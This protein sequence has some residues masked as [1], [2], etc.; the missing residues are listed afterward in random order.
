MSFNY[1]AL[2]PFFRHHQI[3]LKSGE[4]YDATITV[5]T[6]LGRELRYR[7]VVSGNTPSES[8]AITTP[9]EGE[10]RISGEAAPYSHSYVTFGGRC[11]AQ[12]EPSRFPKC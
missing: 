12:L 7:F 5:E 8:F 4:I 3:T 9:T 6:G 11:W 10:Y 1:T 2:G